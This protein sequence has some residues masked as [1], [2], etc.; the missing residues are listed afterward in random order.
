ML[1]VK[2]YFERIPL[3]IAKDIAT[4][5][6]QKHAAEQ[7]SLR[8]ENKQRRNQA[9]NDEELKFPEWQGPF[10]EVLLEFD[11]EKLKEKIHRMETLITE[12]IRQLQEKGN[13]Q[14]EQRALFDALS[15]LRTIKRDKLG[16]PDWKQD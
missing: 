14:V 12:R 7:S 8:V 2:R 6:Y 5:Q 10:R 1:Q 16:F 15:M 13:G 3:W 4:R 11:G 9:M